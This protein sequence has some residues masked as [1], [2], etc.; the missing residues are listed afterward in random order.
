MFYLHGLPF[1][2][3]PSNASDPVRLLKSLCVSVSL[4]GQALIQYTSSLLCLKLKKQQS[5]CGLT[6]LRLSNSDYVKCETQTCGDQNICQPCFFVYLI[7]VYSWQSLHTENYKM[8]TWT[9]I[10][11]CMRQIRKLVLDCLLSFFG[12]SFM[13]MCCNV[14]SSFTPWHTHQVLHSYLGVQARFGGLWQCWSYEVILFVWSSD[15]TVIPVM[16]IF[17]WF[18]LK[19][20]HPLVVE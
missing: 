20:Q 4:K 13:R 19:L 6:A 17:I 7:P 10:R 15:E 16:N 18:M 8:W 14:K 2:H 12:I 5:F 1:T 3:P 9:W 11:T